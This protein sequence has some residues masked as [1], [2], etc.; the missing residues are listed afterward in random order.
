MQSNHDFSDQGFV[1]EVNKIIFEF[2]WKGKDKVKRSVLVSD[3]ETGVTKDL[4]LPTCSP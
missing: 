4:K 2:I 3:I 1:K